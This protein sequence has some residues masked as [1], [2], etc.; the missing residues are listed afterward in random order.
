MKKLLGFCAVIIAAGLMSCSTASPETISLHYTVP[1]VGADTVTC[2]PNTSP[3]PVRAVS[4]WFM[5]GAVPA[6][7]D[8]LVAKKTALLTP[9]SQDSF[10]VSAPSARTMKLYTRSENTAGR[11]CAS[12]VVTVVFDGIPPAK[13]TD[14]GF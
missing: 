7:N 12:N 8:S 10:V 9:G 1:T 13:I 4:L 2:V 6:A 11:S 3:T 14:L 5:R